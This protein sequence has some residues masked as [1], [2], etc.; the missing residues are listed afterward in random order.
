MLLYRITVGVVSQNRRPFIQTTTYMMNKEFLEKLYTAHIQCPECPGPARISRFFMEL[1][2]TLF[3]D[4]AKKRFSSPDELELHLRELQMQ[5]GQM[6]FKGNPEGKAGGEQI[7]SRFFESLPNIHQKLTQDAT[8]LFEGDPAAKSINEVIRTYPGFYA[9]AAYRIA[10]ALHTM[11][12]QIIPRLITEHAHSKTGIDIHPGA[13]IG[14][15]FCI[16]HGTGL[17]IGETTVVGNR[18]KV[19]QGVTL[20]ALSVS[21][22]DARKKRHPTIEDHVTIYAGATILGGETVIGH[23]CIIGGN[24]WITKSVPPHTKVYYQPSQKNLETQGDPIKR[25]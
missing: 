24:V 21:K 15:Y 16:D 3:P 1:L 9:I 18:V 14:D 2:G 8:A 5:L 7:A 13:K 23:H 17:V 6:M 20:G 12:V 11:E 22:E 25:V 10:H 19:Y 4:F